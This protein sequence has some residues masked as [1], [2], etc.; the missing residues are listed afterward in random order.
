MILLHRELTSCIF[1]VA[2]VARGIPLLVLAISITFATQVACPGHGS[3]IEVAPEKGSARH[4]SRMTVR[5]ASRRSGRGLLAYFQLVITYDPDITRVDHTHHH[6]PASRHRCAPASRCPRATH[7]QPPRQFW[8][9]LKQPGISPLLKIIPTSGPGIT[10]SHPP[11]EAGIVTRWPQ[12]YWVRRS[13]M[14]DRSSACRSGR[15]SCERPTVHDTA[16]V[17]LA[18]GSVCRSKQG[19]VTGHPLVARASAVRQPRALE[20]VR[21]SR[22]IRR[23]RRARHSTMPD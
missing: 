6:E 1:P 9:A 10:P 3:V 8:S 15:E 4:P 16:R 22:R 23:P 17:A 5:R 19:G 11:T 14:Q 21:H 18:A 7:R 20:H 2:L 13:A 12:N